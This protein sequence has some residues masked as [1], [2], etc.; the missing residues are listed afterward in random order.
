MKY[1]LGFLFMFESSL[2]CGLELYRCNAFLELS[3]N[4]ALEYLF[5]VKVNEPFSPI[6]DGAVTV[7]RWKREQRPQVLLE[8]APGPFMNENEGLFTFMTPDA[9]FSLNFLINPVTRDLLVRHE[10]SHGDIRESE[11]ICLV[12]DL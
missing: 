9:S 12:E 5:E 8:R 6:E 3:E 1:L 11:G 2:A 10:L 4:T 7:I